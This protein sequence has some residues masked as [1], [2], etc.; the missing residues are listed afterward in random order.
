MSAFYDGLAAT[1]RKL[2]RDKGQAISLLRTNDATYDPATG[3]AAPTVTT[4]GTYGVVLDYPTKEVDGAQVLSTDKKV[5]LES[6][7]A[8]L[9]RDQL[10]IGGAAHNVINCKSLAPD[11]TAV[12]FVVQV[13]AGG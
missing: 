3:A 1:A 7:Y 13:R 4:L 2:I 5:I 8:V 6:S 12:I 11:G 9:P 10:M